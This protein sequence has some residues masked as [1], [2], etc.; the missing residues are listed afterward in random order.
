MKPGLQT[1]KAYLDANI[2]VAYQ[3]GK[4]KEPKYFPLAQDIFRQIIAGKY[5]GI[6]SF[7]TLMETIN[8]FRRI[9]MEELEELGITERNEQIQYVKN[10]SALLYYD[11]SRK[12]AEAHRGIRLEECRGVAISNFLSTSLEI[13]QQYSGT[14]KIYSN[15]RL[16]KSNIPHNVHK[17]ISA[18][19]IL[20]V[21]I[22]RALGCKYFFTF[23]KG[24]NDIVGDSRI[25]N[26]EIKV[27]G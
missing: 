3:V 9:K 24:F 25:K 19:D 5:I 11:L 17:A 10:E 8:V 16:C 18:L 26:L 4:E 21:F 15:C 20:H 12:L 2:L 7:I 23:D 14:V 6:V 13:A 27:F 22:A 1:P